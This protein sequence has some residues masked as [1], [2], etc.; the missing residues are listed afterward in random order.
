MCPYYTLILLLYLPF[1]T[2]F[3]TFLKNTIVRSVIAKFGCNARMGGFTEE[4]LSSLKLTVSFGKEQ[5]KLEE[6]K[7]LALQSYKISKRGAIINGLATGWFYGIMVG[8]SC[9]SWA[10]GFVCIKYEVPN[11]VYDRTMTVYDIMMTYQGLLFAMFTV[12]S[13]QSLI[14]AVIKALTSGKKII[15]LIDRKPLINSPEDPNQR[16][17]NIKIGDGISFDGLRFRYPTQAE[18]TRDVF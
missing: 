9:F 16:V 2:I 14:P 10:I 8:F 4:M 6:Y 17:S 5:K 7:E 3:M 12:L 15:D 1:A 18:Q 13:I 11:P